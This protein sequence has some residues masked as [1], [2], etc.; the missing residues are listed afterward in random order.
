MINELTIVMYHYVR[1]LERTRYPAIKGRRTS[2]FVFQ[3]NHIRKHYNPVTVAE[4]V[5][6]I[7]NG[8]DLPPK[9]LL[10]TFDDG[11]IDHY[12]TCFPILFEAGIQGAFFPPVRP[13]LHSELLDVNRVHFILAVAD[14][15]AI[16]KELDEA[17]RSY[18]D[19]AGLDT[20]QAYR[21]QWAKATRFDTSVTI[22]VKRMLQV[23]LPESIRNEIARDLFAR[24]VSA[25]EAAFA[26]ELYC[27][28]EQLRLM[29]ASGM[30][31]GSHGESHYWLNAVDVGTQRREVEHSL[32]FLREVG[33]P[34]D[35]FWVMCYPYGSWNESLLQVL[36]DYHCSF[37]LTTE[38]GTAKIGVG[39][40]LLLPRLDTNDMPV[41]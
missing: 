41:G 10:M 11:Y 8:D 14:S 7:R 12:S 33:S 27:T 6:C 9:A 30:Y 37:G 13:V 21:A 3:I 18:G 39:N 32:A 34:V 4:I 17:I 35:D 29:Q 25:D 24:H 19:D 40:P 36:A 1:Q 31:V 28:V 2:E 20:P 22:Y 26:A 38:V 23:V 5:H 15:D 16:G